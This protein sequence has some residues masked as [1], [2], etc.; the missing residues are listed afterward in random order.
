MYQTPVPNLQSLL[1]YIAGVDSGQAPVETPPEPA[2][3]STDATGGGLDS[4]IGLLPKLG[5]TTAPAPTGSTS[6]GTR[7]SESGFSP[8]KYAQV[9]KATAGIGQTME[10]E[11]RRAAAPYAAHMAKQEAVGE[12]LKAAS[13]SAADLE[14]ERLATQAEGHSKVQTLYQTAELETRKAFDDARV[15]A[16]IAKADYRRALEEIPQVDPNQLWNSS[17]AGTQFGVAV[18]AFVHDFL[19][20]KGIKTSAMDTINGTIQRNIDAQVANIANKRAVA[21]G[22]KDLWEMQRAQSTSDQEAKIRMQGLML[23]AVKSGIDAQMSGIDSRLAG[24]KKQQARAMIDKEILANEFQ[25][26]KQV[27]AAA[28]AAANRQVQIQGQLLNASIRREEIAEQRAAREA[29]ARAKAAQDQGAVIYDLST[30]GGGAAK[31]RIKK[32]LA[33]DKDL[34]RDVVKKTVSTTKAIEGMR[35]LMELQ[36]KADSAPDGIAKT[37]FANEVTR[38]AEALRTDIVSAIV[39]DASG[40]SATNDEYHRLAGMVPTNTWFTNGG[41]RRIISQLVASKGKEMN[42]LLQATTDDLRPEDPAFGTRAAQ[43][44]YADAERTEAKEV[45]AGGEDIKPALINKANEAITAPDSSSA[46]H[47]ALTPMNE[48]A[49]GLQ[50]GKDLTDRWKDFKKDQPKVEVPKTNGDSI[51]AQFEQGRAVAQNAASELPTKPSKAFGA[52]DTYRILAEKGDKEALK[53]LESW[54][55]TGRDPAGFAPDGSDPN[56]PDTQMKV[57]MA[58]WQLQHMRTKSKE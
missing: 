34:V 53:Q 30:S 29:A 2:P 5:P 20:A 35:Q 52:L 33:H 49:V 38:Q 17:S 7:Q 26:Q 46:E 9:S 4:L 6:T 11:R 47:E 14:S 56:S 45:A 31:W 41:N 10:R 39:L 43:S 36:A 42:L 28:D 32:E 23:A 3:T 1:P 51:E 50:G 44:I 8:S 16:D 24:V 19:G 37:R 12:D 25:V 48:P 15:A 13:D 57:A 55:L 40:K 27:D 18:A 58:R 54:A 22:F 21:Q